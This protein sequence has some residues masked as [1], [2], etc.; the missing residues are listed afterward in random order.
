MAMCF[1]QIVID[2][3][4][5]DTNMKEFPYDPNKPF[6]DL[7]LDCKC[8]IDNAIDDIPPMEERKFIIPITIQKKIF[9]DEKLMNSLYIQPQMSSL[10]NGQSAKLFGFEMLFIPDRKQGGLHYETQSDGQRLYTCYAVCPGALYSAEGY[11]CIQVLDDKGELLQSDY[12]P[13]KG[14]HFVYITYRADAKVVLHHRIVR[15]YMMTESE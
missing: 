12:I 8:A 4:N 2:A 15:F 9:S 14:C 3:M 10:M 1:D 5:V 7:L 6:I 13:R 11:G